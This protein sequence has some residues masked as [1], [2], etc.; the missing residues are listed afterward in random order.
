MSLDMTPEQKKIGKGNF[1]RAV[2]QLAVSRRDFM[3]GLLAAGA[4]PAG[5]GRQPTSATSTQ[6]ARASRSRPA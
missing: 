6:A 3:G 5:V 1:Q 4:V 2:G